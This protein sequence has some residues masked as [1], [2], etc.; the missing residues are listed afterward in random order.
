MKRVY[1]S[2]GE[3]IEARETTVKRIIRYRVSEA[4][5]HGERLLYWF[6]VDEWIKYRR[7]CKR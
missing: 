6:N 2:T 4:R 5:R 7:R 1:F 3:I